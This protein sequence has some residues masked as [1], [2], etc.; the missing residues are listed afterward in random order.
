[1]EQRR[2]QSRLPRKRVVVVLGV[3]AV[4][5]Y[6]AYLPSGGGF[7]PRSGGSGGGA[8]KTL[9]ALHRRW[10]EAVAKRPSPPPVEQP[11][12]EEEAGGD[13]AR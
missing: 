12:E 9:S 4:A 5:L 8:L 11:D 7:G 13:S 3:V 1:M 6:L 10:T 2:P